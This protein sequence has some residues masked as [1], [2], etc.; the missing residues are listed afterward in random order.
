MSKTSKAKKFTRIFFVTDIHGSEI[1]FRKFLSSGKYYEADAVL[2][3]GDL[4]GKMVVPI[5][6]KPD[7]T[8]S[9]R[10]F[11]QEHMAKTEDELKVL[12]DKIADTGYYGYL[13]DEAGMKELETNREKVDALFIELML[14]RL[15]RWVK[16]AEAQYRDTGIKCFMSGG[17]DDPMAIEE[18]LSSSS[19]VVNPEAR[20]VRVDDEHEMI[21]I[22]NANM[23]PWKCPRD[24]T[25]EKLDEIIENLAS[26]LDNPAS[27]IFNLH[28]PPIDST[29]DS[30]FQLDQ[31][32]S[33]PKIVTK[34]GQPMTMGVG[35]TSVRKA[36]E[37]YQPL[38]G[39][40][41]HIHESRGVY[42]LG[43]TLC[44][45]PG[46]EYGEGILRGAIVNIAKDKIASYQMTS[47]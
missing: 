44:V 47:G 17:N 29:L 30:A 21:T 4:T 46:S 34:G 20:V 33:P 19:Y 45:N 38:V 40:H 15:R 35:S 5:V 10:L 27:S 26:K 28:A 32:V 12:R 36:I 1:T 24:V 13:T 22:G 31:S 8:Y 2:L 9:S 25:E 7:G 14:D 42:K 41:G 37:K 43:R 39:L 18:V 11:G 23:T 3:C 16:Q 6:R